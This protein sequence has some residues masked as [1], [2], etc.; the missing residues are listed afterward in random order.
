MKDIRIITKYYKL[1]SIVL[2]ILGVILLNLWIKPDLINENC[3]KGYENAIA[4]EIRGVVLRKFT[5]IDY[6][7]DSYILWNGSDSSIHYSGYPIQNLYFIMEIGD[8]IFKQKS[9]NTIYLYR[10]NQSLTFTIENNCP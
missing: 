8:S 10:E 7:V 9:L 5:D 2:F 3:R 6:G 4:E 1:I